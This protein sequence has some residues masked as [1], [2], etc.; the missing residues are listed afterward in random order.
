M[1]RITG[2]DPSIVSSDFLHWRFARFVDVI[3]TDANGL[4]T[5]LNNGHIDFWPN[6]GVATQPGCSGGALNVF[7]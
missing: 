6:N 5:N 7:F 3:H 1:K 2:L 4:G